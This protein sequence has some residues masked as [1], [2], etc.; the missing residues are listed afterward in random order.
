MCIRD[1]AGHG[2]DPHA[3]HSHGAPAA[4]GHD[5]H[6]HDAHGHDADGHGGHGSHLHDAPKPM[7]VALIVLA[8]GSVL[9][10][11]VGVPHALGGSNAI[12]A[13]L[14]PALMG[15]AETAVTESG[16][17]VEGDAEHHE[18][19]GAESTELALMGLSTAV[20]LSGI[21]IAAFFFLF[22]R[23][24]ADKV[25][26][27]FAALRTLLSNK[28][29]VDEI[30]DATIVQPL[31]LLSEF[32][33]WKIVDAKIIDGTVNGTAGA[34]GLLSS[35]MRRAQ[36]GSVRAYAASLVF[37]VVLVLGYYLWN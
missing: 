13:F 19:E 14:E 10:G 28:Y 16:G 24:A 1:S 35:G 32:G 7:A 34:V 25:A 8:I 33:L 4:H 23:R 22:N 17:A 9:A 20:A 27:S 29:Y 30:Y 3:A 5:A 2:H 36:T 21:G 18:A 12:E 11:Y 37:G 31:K 15:H 6:G 26:E